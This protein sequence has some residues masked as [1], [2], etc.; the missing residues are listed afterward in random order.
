MTAGGEIAASDTWAGR[1][2]PGCPWTLCLAAQGRAYHTACIIADQRNGGDG[3]AAGIIVVTP[4]NNNPDQTIWRT[5]ATGGEKGF[6]KW[7][8]FARGEGSASSLVRGRGVAPGATAVNAIA[9][10]AIEARPIEARRSEAR[11]SG[12]RPLEFRQ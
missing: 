12:V 10:G 8:G 3:A 6:R 9:V 7:P 1:G 11:R 4:D 5:E 2:W